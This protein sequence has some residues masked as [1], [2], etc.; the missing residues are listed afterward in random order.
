MTITILVRGAANK[1]IS[2]PDPLPSPGGEYRE[3]NRET[4]SAYIVLL[5]LRYD[6]YGKW[7]ATGI[8]PDDSEAREALAGHSRYWSGMVRKGTALFAGGM[9]GDYWDNAALIVFEAESMEAAQEIAN[10]DPAVKAFVFQ[11]EVRPFDVH[12]ISNKYSK[13]L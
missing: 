4:I 1:G 5:R 10:Q 9:G 13:P 12:Y 3:A 6:L 8:W 2:Q 11:A 7:K